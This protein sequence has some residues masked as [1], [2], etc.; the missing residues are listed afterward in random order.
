MQNVKASE[1]HWSLPDGEIFAGRS[2]FTVGRWHL[3][4]HYY[5]IGIGSVTLN[6][7]SP[8]LSVVS[9][10]VINANTFR[11][12]SYASATAPLSLS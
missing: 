1:I 9:C 3:P 10:P 2:I 7:G 4:D 6:I 12:V 8:P 11:A 5:L